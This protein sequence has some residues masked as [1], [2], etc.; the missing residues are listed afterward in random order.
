MKDQ[1]DTS[2]ETI[3]KAL[4]LLAQEGYIQKVRGKG[5]IVI[6]NTKLDFPVSG[7]VSFNELAQKMD[8]KP[9][10]IVHELS[11][12][13]PSNI[14]SSSLTYHLKMKCGKLAGFGKLAEKRLF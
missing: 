10:T 14:L 3:R 8:K 13:K 2:R 7:L 6:K 5:S 11:L 1:Y 12:M 9:K 4:N